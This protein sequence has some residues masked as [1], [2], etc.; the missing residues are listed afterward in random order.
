MKVLADECCPRVVVE[1]MRRIGLDVRHAAEADAQTPDTDLLAIANAEVRII[2]NEDF[3]FG[4]LLF[5][6][7]FPAVGAIIVFLPELV[8]DARADRLT[9]VMQSPELTFY[10]KLTI[11]EQRRVRQRALP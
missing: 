11:V 10:G 4:D 5:R 7:R 3:D 1:A 6:D 2:I 9:S 8:P